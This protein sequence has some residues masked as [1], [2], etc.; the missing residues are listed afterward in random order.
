MLPPLDTAIVDALVRDGDDGGSWMISQAKDCLNIRRNLSLGVL[1]L[2]APY[3]P[4]LAQVY[5]DEAPLD[6]NRKGAD[7]WHIGFLVRFP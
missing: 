4:F 7:S 2:L 5:Q 1:M 6:S 3:G